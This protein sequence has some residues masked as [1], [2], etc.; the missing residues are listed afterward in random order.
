MSAVLSALSGVVIAA[1]GIAN[2]HPAKREF[3]CHKLLTQKEYE[4]T[5][6]KLIVTKAADLSHFPPRF[7]CSACFGAVGIE[8]IVAEDGSVA[9]TGQEHTALF[10]HSKSFFSD[11]ALW[12]PQVVE[13][14]VAAMRYV[15]PRVA[16]RP[17]CVGFNVN[18]VWTR[19]HALTRWDPRP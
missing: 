7:S 8:A 12:R 17:V 19:P 9:V 11:D 5:G 15:P 13:E 10:D 14:R 2:G 4:A 6:T 16:G 3:I 1:M 18:W